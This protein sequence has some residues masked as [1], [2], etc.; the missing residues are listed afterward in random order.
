MRISFIKE[1][2]GRFEEIT[3]AVNEGN[4][5][6]AHRL[7]H[8]LKGN[9]GMI[10]ETRLRYAAARVEDL[11]KKGKRHEL[12]EPMNLLE[13]ELK[14][15]LEELMLWQNETA[16][17]GVSIVMDSDQ[18]SAL[19]EQLE[20]MLENLNP[21]CANLLDSLASVPGTE[22]LIFQIEEYDFDAALEALS[23]LKKRSM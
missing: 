3:K 4:L 11:L 14:S 2:Q 17:E 21:D 15:V 16:E 13:T 5:Q 22:E 7:A 18:T 20:S 23:E 6:L 19:L 12:E 9:A 8:S 1:N 10:G